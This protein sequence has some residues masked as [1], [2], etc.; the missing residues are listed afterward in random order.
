M[1]REF[2]ARMVFSPSSS[3]SALAELAVKNEKTITILDVEIKLLKSTI[4][5]GNNLDT[6]AVGDWVTITGM[7]HGRAIFASQVVSQ[8][9]TFVTGVSTVFVAGDI[10]DISM[11]VGYAEIAGVKVY[12]AE[13]VEISDLVLSIGDYVEASGTLPQIGQP[14]SVERV[15]KAE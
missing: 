7:T 15:V 6:L 4:S 11:E 2:T 1:S 5:A 9:D 12:L 10:T 13:A 3:V 14:I 8:P